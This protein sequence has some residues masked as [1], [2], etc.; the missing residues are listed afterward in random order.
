MLC[1]QATTLSDSGAGGGEGVNNGSAGRDNNEQA[2]GD[3]DA[4]SLRI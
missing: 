4:V 3:A 2:V 1:L